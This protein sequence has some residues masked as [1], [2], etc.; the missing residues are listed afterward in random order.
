MG[1]DVVVP[2]H[3]PTAVPRTSTVPLVMAEPRA[4]ETML[5]EEGIITALTGPGCRGVVAAIRLA[6]SLSGVVDQAPSALTPASVD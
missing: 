5:L 3:L 4:S 1:S 6:D 2:A